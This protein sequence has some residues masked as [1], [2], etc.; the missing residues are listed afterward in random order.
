M[1]PLAIFHSSVTKRL[2]VCFWVLIVFQCFLQAQ[3]TTIASEAI[4]TLRNFTISPESSENLG[5]YAKV[6]ENLHN[7]MSMI[8]SESGIVIQP[9]LA[10]EFEDMGSTSQATTEKTTVWGKLQIPDPLLQDR[11]YYLQL[12]ANHYEA[13]RNWRKSTRINLKDI[14]AK[15]REELGANRQKILDLFSQGRE[16]KKEQQEDRIFI[17][18]FEED[19]FDLSYTSDSF[20]IMHPLDSFYFYYDWYYDLIK[21][22]CYPPGKLCR[23]FTSGDGRP[24]LEFKENKL[25]EIK[26]TKIDIN[27]IFWTRKYDWKSLK[28]KWIN[29]KETYN[30]LIFPFDHY[31]NCDRD[32]SKFCTKAVRELLIRESSIEGIKIDVRINKQFNTPEKPLD[33]KTAEK[34]GKISHADLLLW[35]DYEKQCEW[36]STLVNIKFLPMGEDGAVASLIGNKKE[37]GFQKIDA[38]SSLIHNENL[39]GDIKDIVYFSLGKATSSCE[40]KEQLYS[41]VSI[42]KDKLEYI[43]ILLDQINCYRRQKDHEK[44]APLLEQAL[45]IDS[46]NLNVL[47]THAHY[48]YSRRNFEEAIKFYEKINTLYPENLNAANLAE[49]YLSKGHPELALKVIN[50]YYNRRPNEKLKHYYCAEIFRRTRQDSLAIINFEKVIAID[51]TSNILA[52]DIFLKLFRLYVKQEDFPRAENRLDKAVQIESKSTVFNKSVEERIRYHL[53]VKKDTIKALED[54]EYLMQTQHTS[55][56]QKKY[57]PERRNLFKTLGRFNEALADNRALRELLPKDL[58]LIVNE[59]QITSLMGDSLKTIGILTELIDVHKKPEHILERALYYLTIGRFEEAIKGFHEVASSEALATSAYNWLSLIYTQPEHFDKDKAIDYIR[60]SVHHKKARKTPKKNF[61]S[62]NLLPV[63]LL[64]NHDGF[65]HDRRKPNYANYKDLQ[66]TDQCLNQLKFIEDHLQDFFPADSIYLQE[67]F[68]ALA[69]TKYSLLTRSNR[70]EECIQF[71]EDL[72]AGENNYKIGSEEA[73]DLKRTLAGLYVKTGKQ[74][75]AIS[76]LDEYLFS[77][78]NP[79]EGR[80]KNKYLLTSVKKDRSLENLQ[81]NPD[82]IKMIEKYDWL[83]TNDEK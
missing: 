75:E 67:A 57:L 41:K 74:D 82:F 49:M 29:P 6:L 31:D 35:G 36:D 81:S 52:R 54:Y 61:Y 8:L 59:A 64:P 39:V 72:L 43:T 44:I 62:S 45:A 10:T 11:D 33:Y 14:P 28:G 83:I 32:I 76:A 19:G 53:Q 3:K 23:S 22:E 58:D 1:Q 9:D 65:Y 60:Q 47:S 12:E 30:V 13:E 7:E 18:T 40:K 56:A 5:K 78:L 68:Y 71:F 66:F 16:A 69:N 15:F 17:K 73:V 24:F 4:V 77:K 50:N 25:P 38:I 80:D 27:S 37:T 46:T 21:K 2:A 20:F 55:L 51:S 48:Y 42:P 34:I 79:L 63:V 26:N 70:V